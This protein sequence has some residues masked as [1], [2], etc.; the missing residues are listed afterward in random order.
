MS[1]IAG[2]LHGGD[3]TATNTLTRMARAIGRAGDGTVAVSAVRAALVFVG[4]SGRRGAAEAHGLLV[5]V[6]G[7]FYNRAELGVDGGEAEILAALY[8]RHGI[9]AALQKVNGDFAVAVYDPA[10]DTLFLA[11]DRFGAKPLYWARTSD[12]VA[13]ASRLSGLLDLPGVSRT[14]SRRFVATF[15]GS[16]YRTFDNEPAES[17]YADVAQ[18]PAAQIVR[19]HGREATTSAYWSLSEQP[20]RQ[21]PERALAEEYRDLLL[22]A[23]N[24]RMR[25]SRAPMFTLSGGMDSSSVLACAVQGTGKKQHAYSTVYEDATYDESAEIRTI[26]DATVEKWHPVPVGDPDLSVVVPR[27]IAAND[28]PVATATWLSHFLLSERI[29]ADGF[30]EVFGGLGGDELNAGEYEYFFYFFADLKAAGDE[31]ALEHETKKWIEYHDHPIHKKTF[32]AMR[33][34]L[35]RLVD[36]RIPGKCLP[37][38]GRL[39][40]YAATVQKDY[41]DLGAY[42]PVMD[43]PFRSYLKNRTYQDIYRE[44]APCCLRA[45]DRH[46]VA[47]GLDVIWPF[48]DHRLVE[49][50]FRIPATM[51]IRDGVT[52]HLLR[53]AMKDVLPEETRTRIKKTGWNAPA[54]VWFSGAG[55]EL[56]LDLVGSQSFRERGIY[57]VERVRN[58]IDEHQEIVD[59]QRPVENHMMFLWQLLNLELWF[60]A[61]AR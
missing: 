38:V 15:A 9:E 58:I 47:F 24:L 29:A 28:E 46:T 31:A 14:P 18:V 56:L 48:F 45:A 57:D 55:R 59:S 17:P 13:F 35:D 50:M 27:M 30:R 1:R 41:F 4:E 54:H 39:G 5:A 43:T 23:V 51:K 21:E 34:G 8:R 36:L 16:H 33:A 44:T 49:L 19:I 40:R 12:G 53:D 3:P 60:R 52:K 26:L 7:C 11:R 10:L 22:D 25:A 2:L 42:K 32:E 20:D 6:D 61:N 37:D